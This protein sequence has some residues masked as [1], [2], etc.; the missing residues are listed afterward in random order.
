MLSIIKLSFIIHLFIYLLI[1]HQT[2]I[3]HLP[4]IRF[5]FIFG[6]FMFTLYLFP[7]LKKHCHVCNQI[8]F[9]MHHFFSAYLGTLTW[10]SCIIQLYRKLKVS[11]FCITLKLQYTFLE[12]KYIK[13]HISKFY[14]HEDL[15]IHSAIYL[16]GPQKWTICRLPLNTAFIGFGAPRLINFV[17]ILGKDNV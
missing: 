13:Y 16:P 1:C 4:S 8:N 7:F 12:K 10:Y 11:N 14:R 6:V 9:I 3:Y 15:V 17:W 5:L 2:V